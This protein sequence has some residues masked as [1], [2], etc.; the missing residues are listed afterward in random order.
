[1]KNLWSHAKCIFHKG[2]NSEKSN[3]VKARVRIRDISMESDEII[4][5][6]YSSYKY[7]KNTWCV[8]DVFHWLNLYHCF[9]IVVQSRRLHSR[10]VEL[11]DDEYLD[12][13]LCCVFRKVQYD[14]ILWETAVELQSVTPPPNTL[15]ALLSG[16]LTKWQISP[17]FSKFL[18]QSL[19]SLATTV[20]FVTDSLLA[21]HVQV[22]SIFQIMELYKPELNTNNYY[23]KKKHLY[24]VIL[25]IGCFNMKVTKPSYKW[26]WGKNKKMKWNIKCAF[27]GAI[28]KASTVHKTL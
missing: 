18:T 9:V 4:S 27:M 10:L 12:K 24:T 26:G 16:L 13:E 17:I 28:L 15:S 19:L 20:K 2:G 21:W 6:Q 5:P 14:Q 25:F 22:H 1:M 8:I 3:M 11:W 23:G 7:K